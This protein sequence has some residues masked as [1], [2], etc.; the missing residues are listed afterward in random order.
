MTSIPVI[1]NKYEKW[2]RLLI[3]LCEGGMI[4]NK[5]I[6]S[7]LGVKDTTNGK[8]IYKR[9]QLCD[10]S[11]MQH[12]QRF[13]REALFPTSKDINTNELDLS[14]W[15]LIVIL[16]DKQKKYP[17]I[18]RLRDMR[19]ML[20]HMADNERDMTVQQFNKYWHQIS[21][22]LTDLGCD[23]SLFKDL[24]TYDCSNDEFKKRFED[25]EGRAKL[26]FLFFLVFQVIQRMNEANYS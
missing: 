10:E 2:Y 12:L 20:C 22:L 25:I 3:L 16:L 9:L 24:K 4:V 7:K 26:L 14:L 13:Q 23:M 5:D 15:Y 21:C 6:L 11:Q 8:E 19:N 1:W 17:S 18:R